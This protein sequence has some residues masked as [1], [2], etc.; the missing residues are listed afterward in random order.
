MQVNHEKDGG[1][2]VK[3]IVFGQALAQA[4]GR[5]GIRALRRKREKARGGAN[6]A[7]QARTR[8]QSRHLTG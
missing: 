4:E 6:G 3:E 8:R 1:W 7:P 5:L 2:G